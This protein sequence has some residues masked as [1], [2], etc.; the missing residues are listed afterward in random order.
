[1]KLEIERFFCEMDRCSSAPLCVE[2]KWMLRRAKSGVR[3]EASVSASWV[4]S[5]LY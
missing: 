1:M 2:R 4:R 5:C 3:R